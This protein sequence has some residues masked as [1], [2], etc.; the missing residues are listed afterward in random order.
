MQILG[1]FTAVMQQ[2]R[3]AITFVLAVGL[4]L[5]QFSATADDGA[6]GETDTSPDLG[7]QLPIT[8]DVGHPTFASPHSDPIILIDDLVYVVNTPDD[9]LDVVDTQSLEV[10]FRIPVGVDPVALGLTPDGT[11]LWVSNHV[12]D[13]ISVINLDPESSYYHQIVAT[14]QDVDI[15]TIQTNFDEPV[16]I[17]FANDEKAYVAL[18]PSNQIA[19][20]NVA[21]REVTNYLQVNAQDPRALLVDGEYLYV[22]AF[23]SGNTTQLSGCYPWDIDG[24]TCTYDAI[25]ETHTTNNVLSLNYDVDIVRNDKVPDRDLFIFNT[26]TD[27]L[28]DS[29]EGTGTLL[30]G[31]AIDSNRNV[32]IAQAEARND[33]N[34]KAGTQGHGLLE[35][36]NRAFLNQI[37]FVSCETLPCDTPAHFDLEPLPPEHPEEGMGLATP[38]AIKIGSDDTTIVA[39]A[40]GSDMVFT[41]DVETGEILGRVEV[42]S[43]P[44]GLAL[45][46]NEDGVP[47]QAWVFNAVSNS[48][49]LLDLADL[50]EPTVTNTVQLVD[51]TPTLMKQGRMAFHDANAS[52]TGTFSCD[53]CHPDNNVDQ[54]VW[55]LDTPLCDHPGCTQIPPRLTMPVRGLRGTAPYHWDGI[56]GDP[57]G[58]INVSS[59]WDDVEANCSLDD[60]ETCT[61]FLVDGS[62]GT[63]MCDVSDC[64]TN[65]AENSGA[66]DEET[67]DALAHYILNVPFP[68]APHRPFDNEL[69]ASAKEGI[70]EFNYL[71]DSG[72]ST[73]AQACGACHKAPFLTTTNTPS[74]TN[75]NADVGSFNGMDAPTWRGAYDRWI[76]TPQARFN[77]IDLIERIGM[78]LGGD[79]PEQEIWFHAGARTQANWDMV[80]EYSTGFSGSFARQVTLDENRG[81]SE[82]NQVLLDTLITAADGGHVKLQAD[83]I[84]I[85]EEEGAVQ[86]VVLNY[87]DGEFIERTVEELVVYERPEPEPEGEE[88]EGDGDGSNDGDDGD[89]SGDSGDGDNGDGN[90]GDDTDEEVELTTY[91]L[92]EVLAAIDDGSLILTLTARIGK[93][94]NED[95]PQPGIWPYWSIGDNDYGGIVEQS[96]TVEITD[97]AEDL[98]LDIK[99]RHIQPDSLLFVNGHRVAGSIACADGELPDCTD[100]I[101]TIT[102]DEAPERFGLNFLQIQ[103]PDG[104][105]SN[106]LSFFSEQVDKPDYS[107]NLIVSGGRFTF[108]EFPLQR[109]WNTVELDGNAISHQDFAI[110]ASIAAVNTTQPWRAQISHT[111][112]VVDG[113]EYSLCYRAKASGSRF[114]TAYL[115]RNMH[116]WQNISGGQFRANLTTTWQDFQHTFTVSQTDITA[117]VAF[118]LAQSS[119]SV[120]L[121]DIGLY[122]GSECGDPGETYQIGFTTRETET[123]DPE[124]EGE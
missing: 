59:L 4:I 28:V 11:E 101:L 98:T 49:S 107:G 70:F 20:I 41:V 67:R 75:T 53:S 91:T 72:I 12:S 39:T 65:E 2:W 97:L 21:N 10:V 47:T 15:E 22:I 74:A 117:R 6:E 50:S 112:P 84:W 94:I 73:G 108:F 18:G 88:G 3:P 123:E 68:P 14:I 77:V 5:A 118:D 58:G 79:L 81:E 71:N 8:N 64:P 57:Y 83:G 89:T 33:A 61:R 92:E 54:L 7:V 110:N 85:G 30:Y 122:E 78:D 19:V 104:F 119:F 109:F 52:T 48:V 35:M 60:E 56:P 46:E 106:D 93:N 44:R 37:T 26:T 87:V 102:F 31:L 90:V 66:L 29:V 100:E 103:T 115:D 23:E 120:Q 24:E 42:E 55:I 96:P 63:T 82:V 99:G 38:F 105:I 16:G 27:L 114:I 116:Q 9:T 36:E 113:Q 1:T 80:L 40:A 76:I 51:P 17:A 43:V 13:T 86:P 124:T 34:G 45:V 121:D 69:S 111:V 32:Y 62:L 95:M 25:Q